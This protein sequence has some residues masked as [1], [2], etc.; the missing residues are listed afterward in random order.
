MNESQPRITEKYSSPEGANESKNTRWAEI[1]KKVDEFRDG[2]DKPIDIG[3]RETL[4]AMNA[5][6]FKTRQSCEG[7]LDWG[8]AAPW[9]E[10]EVEGV[11]SL[12]EK[13]ME[14]FDTASN[15]QED[16]H[17]PY[18][19]VEELFQEAHRMKAEARKPVLEKAR[20]MMSLLG[21]FYADYLPP[22]DQI[23]MVDV[24][25]HGFRVQN[26][27]I[28]LQQIAD[29]ETKQRKLQAYKEEMD[30]FAEFLKSKFFSE[31]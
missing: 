19:K 6:G 18:D 21:E 23:L 12:H 27:G 7:H 29:P 25:P 11:E 3:I 31:K 17:T 22:H 20:Q 1:A 28:E 30:D 5:L 15:A 2:L 16:D 4:I 14:M 9:V 26:I 13:A 10:I 8:L 24:Y